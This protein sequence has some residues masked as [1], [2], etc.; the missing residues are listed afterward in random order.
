MQG[1]QPCT[2]RAE[3]AGSE[4]PKLQGLFRRQWVAAQMI[5][6]DILEVIRAEVPVQE[7]DLPL[8]HLQVRHVGGKEARFTQ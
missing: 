4:L 1:V 8:D 7:S 2:G 3:K 6:I 5:F